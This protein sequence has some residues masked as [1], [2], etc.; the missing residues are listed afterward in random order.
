MPA[1]VVV[2]LPRELWKQ[3]RMR[4]L[5]RGETGLSWLSRCA[6]V[7]LAVAEGGSDVAGISPG[8]VEPPTGSDVAP[9]NAAEEPARRGDPS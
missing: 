1:T 3:I 2:R 5:A 8:A 9:K 4:A 7:C 6:E